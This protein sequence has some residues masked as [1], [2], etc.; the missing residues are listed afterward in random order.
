M[1]QP[2]LIIDDLA[3]SVS[4]WPRKWQFHGELMMNN[5]HAGN[6]SPSIAA[7]VHQTTQGTQSTKMWRFQQN[8]RLWSK[9][10]EILEESKHKDGHPKKSQ[11]WMDGYPKRTTLLF[12]LLMFHYR[13]PGFGSIPNLQM[14]ESN[15]EH[16]PPKREK[17]KAASF[18]DPRVLGRC[19]IFSTW[20]RNDARICYVTSLSDQDALFEAQ[21]SVVQFFRHYSVSPVFPTK[22]LVTRNMKI[23]ILGG[24]PG[25]AKFLKLGGVRT[26]SLHVKRGRPSSNGSPTGP[27]KHDLGRNGNL[28]SGRLP[29][30]AL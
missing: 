13:V 5:P 4:T 24:K 27:T 19:L 28:M 21:S 9:F 1:P 6:Q 22:Q 30:P 11:L 29:R 15:A 16:F 23:A 3:T 10:Q 2:P 14:L 26:P 7:V 25:K 12:I 8:L 20:L 18:F 17:L